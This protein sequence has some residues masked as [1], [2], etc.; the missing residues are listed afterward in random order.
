MRLLRTPVDPPTSFDEVGDGLEVYIVLARDRDLQDLEPIR[1]RKDQ[2]TQE[3][4]VTEDGE[5]IFVLRRD[6]KKD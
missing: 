6:L 4:S 5:R 1:A 2:F 3:L